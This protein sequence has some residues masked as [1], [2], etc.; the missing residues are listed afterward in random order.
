ML[1]TDTLDYEFRIWQSDVTLHGHDHVTGLVCLSVE[2]KPTG[3]LLAILLD[4]KDE[5]GFYREDVADPGV[6]APMTYSELVREAELRGWLPQ[7]QHALAGLPEVYANPRLAL[8]KL[9]SEDE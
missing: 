5:W 1:L 4:A 9:Y 3:G 8:D 7:L 2:H 6:R